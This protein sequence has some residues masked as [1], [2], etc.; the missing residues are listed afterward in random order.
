MS[1]ARA[2][3]TEALL[4]LDVALGHSADMIQATLP[5]IWSKVGHVRETLE[6]R[7]GECRQ[8]IVYWQSCID[9]ADEDEDTSGYYEELETWEE[10]LG[11][12]RTWF[13][14]VD[15]AEANFQGQAR[16]LESLAT[17][18]AARARSFLRRR[19]E[20]IEDYA[21]LHPDDGLAGFGGV[22]SVV[23]PSKRVF[24]FTWGYRRVGKDPRDWLWSN[25]Y[26]SVPHDLPERATLESFVG[27]V[28][29]QGRTPHCVCHSLAGLRHYDE[30]RCS[31]KWVQFDPEP[32]YK[33]CKARDGC[34]DQDGTTVRDAMKVAR[35]VGL[36]GDDGQRYL[37]PGYARME[38]AEE[39]KHALSL[40]KTVMLGV[41]IANE[42]L[43]ALGRDALASPSEI[44]DGGHCMLVVGYDEAHHAFR[45]R[46]SWGAGWADNGHFWL[47]YSY[48]LTDPEFEAWTTVDG[49][50]R[51]P[52]ESASEPASELPR[53]EV[54]TSNYAWFDPSDVILSYED[55]EGLEWK[56][57][58]KEF[59]GD[60]LDRIAKM[61]SVINLAALKGADH[62]ALRSEIAT[63]RDST[64]KPRLGAE[65]LH[66]FDLFFGGDAI[67]IDG[68]GKG[69]FVVINGR[70]RLFLAQQLGI[71]SV[72]VSIGNLGRKQM[73]ELI[74]REG[75]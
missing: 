73:R 41:E 61:R 19:I 26:G 57:I 25:L 37:I 69:G 42:E 8:Q 53:R 74:Q 47:P 23:P 12:V 60:A 63:L 3:S 56:R 32:I 28:S 38:T 68:D 10:R 40:G 13:S 48:L 62:A 55:G 52:E 14:R 22:G 35:K 75:A 18:N 16:R 20:E 21:A 44:A 36:V 65:D 49:Q 2:G 6:A 45:V 46:N 54:S 5:Q 43:S 1:E 34:P 58:T 67:R 50:G 31:E 70:H 27:P 51:D 24:E 7:Q 4:A 29:D 66:A 33:Q 11:Q 39:I 71:P 30:V 72:P 59:A 17:Q 9:D 64:G 15:D